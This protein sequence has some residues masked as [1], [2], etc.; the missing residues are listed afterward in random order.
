MKEGRKSVVLSYSGCIFEGIS[1][2]YKGEED[3]RRRNG[4]Y[5]HTGRGEVTALF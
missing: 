4:K 2:K 5:R 1:E 3:G